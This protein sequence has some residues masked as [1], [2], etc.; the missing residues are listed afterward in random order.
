[1]L[2][3]A[4]LVKLPELRLVTG[5][6][7]LLMRLVAA[8]IDICLLLHFAFF[9]LYRNRLTIYFHVFVV[10]GLL[11]G[12]VLKGSDADLVHVFRIVENI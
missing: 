5:F 10:E 3:C 2:S 7:G 9:L 4:W 1:M 11:D 6:S 8:G 12:Y